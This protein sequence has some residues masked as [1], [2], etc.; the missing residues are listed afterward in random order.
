M[1]EVNIVGAFR[2]EPRGGYNV[3]YLKQLSALGKE[4]LDFLE[5]DMMDLTV[6]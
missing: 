4:R 6:A 5:P 3:Q 2:D 1:Q